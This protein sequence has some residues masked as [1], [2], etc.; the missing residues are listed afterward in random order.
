[1]M[2]KVIKEEIQ[3]VGQAKIK[4]VGVGGGGGNAVNQMITEG[5]EDVEYYVIN[6]DGQALD[7]SKAT[8]ILIGQE[9]TKG[10]GAGANPEIGKRAAEENEDEIRKHLEGA[11]L[12]YIAAGMGGGTGTG[13]APIVAKV[14]KELGIL[15]IGVVTLPFFF[16]GPRRMK[17]AIE[18]KRSMSEHVDTLITIPNDKIAES[19]ESEVELKSLKMTDAYA[20]VDSILVKATA[21]VTSLIHNKGH[22]N[23]DFADIRT[24]IKVGGSSVMGTGRSRGEDAATIAAQKAIENPLFVHSIV[25]A[26]GVIMN[27]K[28]SENISFFEIQ[29]AA[30]EVQ[31]KVCKDAVVIFGHVVAEEA[32]WEEDEVEVTMVATGFEDE[33]T[34]FQD[35]Q[36]HG[37]TRPQG[38]EESGTDG[39]FESIKPAK[40]EQSLAPKE[41]E[42]VVIKGNGPGTTQ[43]KTFVGRNSRKV[44]SLSDL[45]KDKDVLEIPSFLRSRK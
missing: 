32:D 17:Q 18:G 23:L 11:D 25:G 8:K 16:E 24:V 44:E 2:D 9:S 12:I 31:S 39:I 29:A 15:S 42:E 45:E 34:M 3:E 1:M 14:A 43:T 21:G 33:D 40:S 13:A 26:K 28:T 27:F 19:V 7:N 22:I 20:L 5:Y 41:A 35:R 6:T 30:T 38:N 4:V 36:D 37:E 10:L